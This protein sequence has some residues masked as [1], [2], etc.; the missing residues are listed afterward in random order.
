MDCG[1]RFTAEGEARGETDGGG[2]EREGGV[3]EMRVAAH[4]SQQTKTFAGISI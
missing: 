4:F 2:G 1:A 3:V